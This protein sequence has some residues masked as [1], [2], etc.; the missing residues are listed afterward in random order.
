MS[1]FVAFVLNW[2]SEANTQIRRRTEQKKGST[3]C[4]TQAG[5]CGTLSLTVLAI[6]INSVRTL[7]DVDPHDINSELTAA[8]LALITTRFNYHSWKHRRSCFKSKHENCRFRFPKKTCSES[9]VII[10]NISVV[11]GRLKI[12]S[13]EGDPNIEIQL[14]RLHGDAYVN[15]VVPLLMLTYRCNM[16]FTLCQNCP[17]AVLYM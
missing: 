7:S 13:D 17:G 1:G 8:V 4:C 12:N 9:N 10:E 5:L 2:V 11:N 6:G 15:S 14:K 16:D 3:G